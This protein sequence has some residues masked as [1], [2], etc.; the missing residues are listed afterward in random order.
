MNTIRNKICTSKYNRILQV[1]TESK[2]LV[3]DFMELRILFKTS[4]KIK[5]EN[6][7]YILIFTYGQGYTWHLRNEVPPQGLTL[8]NTVKNSGIRKN[9]VA[10]PLL[11]N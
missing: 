10:E 3:E 9:I 6:K 5:C 11:H 4:G 2:P 1:R 7:I 8:H